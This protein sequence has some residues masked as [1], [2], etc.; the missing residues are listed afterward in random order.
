MN[1]K[2]YTQQNAFFSSAVTEQDG[3]VI[4]KDDHCLQGVPRPALPYLLA[5]CLPG[6]RLLRWPRQ[7]G[8]YYKKNRFQTE[9]G[10]DRVLCELAR[11]GNQMTEDIKAYLFS[12]E[13]N[14]Y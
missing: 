5:A 9:K 14:R 4:K 1:P 12:S 7:P 2:T 6:N 11:C 3:F 10:V 13:I 8:R